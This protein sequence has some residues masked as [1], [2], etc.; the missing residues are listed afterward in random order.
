MMQ[1]KYRAPV[2]TAVW[3]ISVSLVCAF[4]GGAGAGT[5]FDG[6]AR[7]LGTIW[8]TVGW[9]AMIVGLLTLCW[10]AWS[11]WRSGELNGASKELNG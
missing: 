1:G 3:M 7:H 10:V 5:I 9:I 11:M 8:D 2:K 4:I 6:V